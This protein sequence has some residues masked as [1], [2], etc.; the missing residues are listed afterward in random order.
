MPRTSAYEWLNCQPLQILPCIHAYTDIRYTHHLGKFKTG[1]HS[2]ERIPFRHDD[3][4]PRLTTTSG[5]AYRTSLWRMGLVGPTHL[6][7]YQ[8]E[9]KLNGKRT[10]FSSTYSREPE[11]TNK[12]KKFPLR[13]HFAPI[14][15]GFCFTY[16][17][18][19]NG[20]PAQGWP[21]IHS[22]ARDL[23]LVGTVAHAHGFESRGERRRD[24]GVR[25]N[26]PN[27]F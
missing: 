2:C 3:R 25:E 17:P 4:S 26:D 16:P 10:S 9:K 1:E 24:C 5:P 23:T 8:R 14:S 12:G 18:S 22:M 15:T 20:C 21:D 11:I 27:F 7:S 19:S 6:V 13:A